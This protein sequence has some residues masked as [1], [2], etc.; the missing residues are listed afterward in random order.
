VVKYRSTLFTLDP[1]PPPP[2]P[3][4]IVHR[5]KG[6]TGIRTGFAGLAK[7][8]AYCVQKHSRLG[9]DAR[10]TPRRMKQKRVENSKV[11]FSEKAEKFVK[12]KKGYE[13]LTAKPGMFLA[14]KKSC[15]QFSQDT[16]SNRV[17]CLYLS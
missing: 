1:P 17:P 13:K 14:Q 8:L 2:P 4:A 3:L 10:G 15:Q 5:T 16:G 9:F 6:K 12:T 11:E 7:S